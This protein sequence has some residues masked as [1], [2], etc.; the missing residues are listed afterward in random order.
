MI[1][2]WQELIREKKIFPKWAGCKLTN[3]GPTNA[4]QYIVLVGQAIAIRPFSP[5]LA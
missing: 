1:E 4:P 2:V 3:C 5:R